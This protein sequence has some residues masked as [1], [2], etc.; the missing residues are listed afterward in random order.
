MSHKK[1]WIALG[2][3][4]TISFAVLDGVGVCLGAY[5]PGREWKNGPLALGF[6]SINLG[7]VLMGVLSML[8]FGLMQTWASVEVGTC[9]A[10]SSGFLHSGHMNQ[11]RWMRMFGDTVFSAGVV[12]LGWFVVGLITGHSYGTTP[13]PQTVPEEDAV[14][15][16]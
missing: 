10:R 12:A 3:V 14:L 11:L 16:R 7:L 4:L 1:L 8:P 5:R 6:W 9:Y 2:F 13:A 15:A